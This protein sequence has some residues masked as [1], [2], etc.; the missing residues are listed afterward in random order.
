M[1]LYGLCTLSLGHEVAWNP[2]RYTSRLYVA[3]LLVIV[4][5]TRRA[6]VDF[7]VVSYQKRSAYSCTPP[8]FDNSMPKTQQISLSPTFL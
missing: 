7:V 3:M 6:I 8:L 4:Y 2:L 1:D 5:S